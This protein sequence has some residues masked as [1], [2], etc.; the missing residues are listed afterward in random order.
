MILRLLLMIFPRTM[1]KYKSRCLLEN[2]LDQ[3][4]VRIETGNIEYLNP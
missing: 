4:R 1:R 2:K 3:L